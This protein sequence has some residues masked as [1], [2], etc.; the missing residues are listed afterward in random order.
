MTAS[1][2]RIEPMT[3]ADVDDVAAI[4]PS[5][6]ATA[7]QLVEELARPWARIWIAREEGAPVSAFLLTWHVADELHV[8]N[9]A[10]RVERRR[11]G[12]ARALLCHAIA[13]AQ[14]NAIRSIFLEVRRSNAAALALYG[15]L[16]FTEINVRTGYYPDGEDAVE[17][18]HTVVTR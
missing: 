5:A 4:E 14:D 7:P 13:Y 18:A 6:G 11:R 1:P 12:L 8:L 10:T 16:A 3:V 15:S 17:M 9:V 2:V